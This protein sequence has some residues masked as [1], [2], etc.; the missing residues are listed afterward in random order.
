LQAKDRE[1]LSRFFEGE[2]EVLVA[3]LFGSSARGFSS[4]ESDVD[5]A[6]LLA[7]AAGGLL[8]A[9]LRLV[10]GLSQVLGDRLDLVILNAAP[11]LLKYQVIKHGKVVFCRDER[12]RV[13]FE[14]R[15]MSEYLDLAIALRR[16]DECLLR[17]MLK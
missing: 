16:Y 12:A 4:L 2:H 17:R 13:A 7:T 9:Y 15:A 10:D 8:D 5:I 1:A 3:Y 14:A 6:V 11:P